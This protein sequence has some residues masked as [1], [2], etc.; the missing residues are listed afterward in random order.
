MTEGTIVACAGLVGLA[1]VA[2]SGWAGRV[3]GRPSAWLT[4]GLHVLL[5]TLGGAGAAA[6]G[7]SWAEVATFAL[8]ALGWALLVARRQ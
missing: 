2:L 5:A 6:L 3:A 8:L 4:S 7:R 1:A